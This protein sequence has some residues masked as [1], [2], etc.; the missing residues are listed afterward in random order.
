VRFRLDSASSAEMARI[1]IAGC[2][3]VGTALGEQLF[4][5]GHEVFGLRRDPSG[6]PDGIRPIR[7][8]LR[9]GAPLVVLPDG[10]DFAVYCVGASGADEAAYRSAYLDGL[11]RFLRALSEQGERPKRIFFTSS[12]SV[13]A[14]QRGE[15]VDED[16]RTRPRHFAGEILLLAERLLHASAFDATVVRLGGI[17]G[18]GRTRLLERVARG[19][20][21]VRSDSRHYTNRIHRDDAAGALRHLM[22]GLAG[23]GAPRDLYLGV[24]SEPADEA[25][26]ARFLAAALGVPPPAE[27][28]GAGADSPRRSGSKRCRNDRLLAAGYALRF[29]SFRDGYADLVR[30]HLQAS[31]PR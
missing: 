1:V 21:R 15:W 18:P 9:S 5:D 30:R 25:E 28:G 11:A 3:Y 17:Y 12:T 6:L 4:A 13:Y 8:D 24:D 29:P 26:V 14:Q 16:S 7:A 2:G 10:V 20:L 23:A 19:E 22:F 27:S 31:A